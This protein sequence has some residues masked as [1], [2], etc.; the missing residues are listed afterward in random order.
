MKQNP[1]QKYRKMFFY[2]IK[3]HKQQIQ[4]LSYKT[5]T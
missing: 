2:Y 1:A 4:A 3:H 5:A